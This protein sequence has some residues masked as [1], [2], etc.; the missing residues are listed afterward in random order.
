MM[1][2]ESLPAPPSSPQRRQRDGEPNPTPPLEYLNEKMVNAITSL[3]VND[4]NMWLSDSDI[5]DIMDMLRQGVQVGSVSHM[6]QVVQKDIQKL[7]EL[8]RQVVERLA[9]A[10]ASLGRLSEIIRDRTAVMKMKKKE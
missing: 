7:E 2:F 10:Y 3:V 6:F 5:L 9:A 4:E 8:K 1:E